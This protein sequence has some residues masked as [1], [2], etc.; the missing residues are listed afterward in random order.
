MRTAFASLILA[1]GLAGAAQAQAPATTTPAPSTPTPAAAPPSGPAPTTSSQPLPPLSPVPQA[2]PASPAGAAPQGAPAAAAAPPPVLPTSGDGA[3]VLSVLEKVC[4]PIVRGQKLEDV[5][6]A[7]GMKLNRRDGSWTMGLG[8]D[9]NYTVSIFPQGSNKDVCQGEVHF[10]VGQDKP[11]VGAINTW[12][13]LHQPEL[14]LQANY[15]NV[16]PDGI[17]RVRKSWEHLESNA[18]IAVNFSTLSKPDGSSLNG[19]F[20]TGTLFY[21]ERKF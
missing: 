10:A 14:I 17:K 16:D 13:F 7:N 11:I 4:V 3:V 1:A 20:D 9:K 5:A 19:R 21:Q 2:A 6:K 18:S 12:A 8:G 15:V